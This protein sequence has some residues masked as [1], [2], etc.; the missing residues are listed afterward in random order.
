MTPTVEDPWQNQNYWAY[1]CQIQ[2]GKVVGDI[3]HLCDQRVQP[4][5]EEYQRV[6]CSYK[7]ITP[8]E[9]S[10]TS[11]GNM[12][13]ITAGRAEYLQMFDVTV[14]VS[15]E[16]NL[17]HRRRKAVCLTFLHSASQLIFTSLPC[18]VGCP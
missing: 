15:R 9:Y 16:E 14:S 5:T 10:C 13:T 12:A 18:C 2:L 17:L 6:N 4:V 7:N 1:L 3:L 8:Q 11:L